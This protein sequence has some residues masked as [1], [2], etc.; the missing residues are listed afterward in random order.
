MSHHLSIYIEMFISFNSS[1][2]ET[3]TTTKRCEMAAID[4][5][6]SDW[7]NRKTI[8][9]TW[10]LS[11]KLVYKINCV[12]QREENAKQGDTESDN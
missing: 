10:F 1:V 8:E 7:V 5:Q 9:N 12:K 11:G 6:T 4:C 3:K 2:D